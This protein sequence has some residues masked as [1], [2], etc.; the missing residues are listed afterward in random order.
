[1]S[2]SEKGVNGC[3][4]AIFQDVVI[5]ASHHPTV[6]SRAKQTRGLSCTSAIVASDAGSC[7]AGDQMNG[8]NCTPLGVS[9]R[10]HHSPDDAHRSRRR[11]KLM[12]QPQKAWV[13]WHADLNTTKLSRL[14]FGEHG[15][16]SA[17]SAPAGLPERSGIISVSITLPIGSSNVAHSHEPGRPSESRRNWI[18]HALLRARSAPQ[19]AGSRLS[20][21]FPR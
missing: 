5:R 4:R 11:K 16:V 14:P 19:R 9:N 7:A 2:Q 17:S 10:E 12:A 18:V 21:C 15:H 6:R 1:M 13:E 3:W 8:S 20:M